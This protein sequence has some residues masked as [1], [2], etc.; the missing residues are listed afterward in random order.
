MNQGWGNC[1][2]IQSKHSTSF[3]YGQTCKWRH[4]PLWIIQ[5]LAFSQKYIYIYIYLYAAYLSN[6]YILL[7]T[8]NIRPNIFCEKVG[9]PKKKNP[10]EKK[11][12]N[13]FTRK[14]V[15]SSHNS[16][17]GE[18]Y[19]Q[20]T[21]WMEWKIIWSTRKM[22]FFAGKLKLSGIWQLITNGFETKGDGRCLQ[23]KFR[24]HTRLLAENC[25]IIFNFCGIRANFRRYSR[26]WNIFERKTWGVVTLRLS[27]Y[28]INMAYQINMKTWRLEKNRRHLPIPN[29]IDFL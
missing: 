5:W 25:T 29:L 8:L 3:R 7:R 18:L 23:H 28:F 2:M 11:L 19:N 12:A 4:F 22:I 20:T 15:S 21:C 16:C 17:N 13:F 27:N 10:T 6:L 1:E 9:K 14:G 26:A 24:R